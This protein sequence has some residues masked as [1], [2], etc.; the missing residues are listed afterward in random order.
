MVP[1]FLARLQVEC[2]VSGMTRPAKDPHGETENRTRVA[3]SRGGRLNHKANEAVNKERKVF[4]LVCFAA[5]SL[6][7]SVQRQVR[8]NPGI[9]SVKRTRVCR[10]R[11]GRLNHTANEAVSKEGK[12]SLWY[13]AQ[14]HQ[15]YRLYK[16]RSDRCQ[17]NVTGEIR[18]LRATP[19]SF[20]FLL[21][22]T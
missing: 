2:L 12:Y 8:S 16:D 17:H 9:E 18:Y 15:F 3:R 7:S 1:S 22:F 6:L 5:S 19:C 10:S 11:G 13:A 21:P 4:S 14:C 20:P